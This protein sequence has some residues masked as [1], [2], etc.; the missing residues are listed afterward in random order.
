M[1]DPGFEDEGRP[2]FPPAQRGRAQDEVHEWTGVTL[3]PRYQW[4]TCR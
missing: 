2:G 1:D 4:E 3:N